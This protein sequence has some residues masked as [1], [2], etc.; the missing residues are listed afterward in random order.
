MWESDLF[1]DKHGV[2]EQLLQLFICVVD[3]QLLK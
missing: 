2:V 1:K 3:A